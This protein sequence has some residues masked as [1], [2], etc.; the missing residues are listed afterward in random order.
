MLDTTLL[1][2][3]D[4]GYQTLDLF[5]EIP[6]SI[7]YSEL[8]ITEVDSRFSPYSQTFILPGT[9]GNNVVFENFYEVNGTDF[10][11]LNDYK[12]V[13]QYKGTDI[14]R[15]KLR[16][17]KVIRYYDYHEFEVY[18]TSE[19]HSLSSALKDTTLQQLDWADYYFDMN[20]T[21]VTTSWSANT[22]NNQGLLNGDI[23][24]PLI[25]Y[26]LVVQSGQTEP[27]WFFSMDDD[28][29]GGSITYSGNAMSPLYFKPA[30]RIKAVVDKIF[31]GTGFNYNSEFFETEYF[32][33]IYMDTAQNGELGPVLPSGATNENFFKVYGPRAVIYEF[34]NGAQQVLP[35]TNFE[36]DGFDGLDN[37]TFYNQNTGQGGYFQVPYSGDY[38]WN[39]RFRYQS[40][41]ASTA[42]CFFRLTVR[43]ADNVN[44]LPNGNII[45]TTPG[46]G[47]AAV[48]AFQ[49]TNQFFSG[50]CL[51]GQY[52]QP[53]IEII[54]TAGDRSA[55]VYIIGYD[56]A[57]IDD[58]APYW[59][60]YGSPLLT[61]QTTI[62]MK[63]QMPDITCMNFFKGL[64]D[65]FNL[66]VTQDVEE[67][68]FKIEP[69]PWYFDETQRTER[70]WTEYLDINSSVEIS[71]LNFDLPK[72]INWK[73]KYNENET[74]NRLY[75]SNYQLLFGEKR[76]LTDTSIP[77]GEL[78][79]ETP[80]SPLPTD[81]ISGSTN[82]IIPQLWYQEKDPANPNKQTFPVPRQN[83]PHLFFW[84]GNRY[85][86]KDWGD[87][88]TPNRRNWWILSGNTPVAQTTYP[89]VSHISSLDT[90]DASL[91][92]E[93]NFNPST[94]YYFSVTTD[95]TKY[96]Q[97]TAYR[98]FWQTHIEN[99]FSPNARKLTGSF[100]M[101]PQYYA[102]LKLTDKIW[103][104]DASYRIDTIQNANL[105]EPQSTRIT[106]VKDLNLYYKE[107][108]WAPSQ[109]IAPNAAYPPSPSCVTYPINVIGGFNAFV[110]CSSTSP[111]QTLY[112]DNPAGLV[113]GA[114]IFTTSDCAATA[115]T[116]L[117]LRLT[118]STNQFVIDIFGTALTNGT[119]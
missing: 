28:I 68:T 47:M 94:D 110:V 23:L 91:V 37:L 61:T 82:V 49:N 8:S 115:P 9:E 24:M 27:D 51:A 90:L 19:V 108:L 89:C 22:T 5:Q 66:V 43:V 72:Q 93:L 52:V 63:L 18:I 57:V 20:Y 40:Y 96:V 39:I 88:T 98:Y 70:D 103:I 85:F 16:L 32:R 17:N 76:F 25:N 101:S 71:A 29:L 75:L 48:N 54:S 87:Y 65:Q 41:F 67:N 95:F 69:L 11:P 114:R 42:P 35:F 107:T 74:L 50:T 86:W 73:G 38:F 7:T 45:Y 100:I 53:F 15:G 77:T 84:V 102:D 92:S 113:N 111:V 26:G 34:S 64:V 21:S 2:L 117:Y 104:K 33:S 116:G 99:L 56:G 83:S 97:N 58:I 106:L 31:S 13:V 109:G 10:N 4:S 118:G 80:F 79:I 6:I 119:C 46:G 112:S 78:I 105:V 12:C 60:L 59:D 14:F 1:L 62:D 44:D 3:T 55:G 30:I 36:S 81:F